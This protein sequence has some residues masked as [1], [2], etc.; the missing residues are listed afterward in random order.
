MIKSNLR[1]GILGAS[2]N[3]PHQGHIHIS[4]LAIQKF[5]F[6]QI[7]WIPTKYNNFKALDIYKSYE[8][9]VKLCKE[10]TKNYPFIKVKEYSEIISYK[11]ILKL[12]NKYKHEFYWIMGADNFVNFHKWNFYINFIESVPIIIFD[13]GKFSKKIRKTPA[14]NIYSSLKLNNLRKKLLPMFKI[15]YTKN[16]N[17]SSTEI[18]KKEIKNNEK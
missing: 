12:Q 14:Y 1:V 5:G 8:E 15:Y 16:L 6:K 3:P 4:K 18:R 11:L 17:I 13:R 7:W 9:R 2:F 10:L